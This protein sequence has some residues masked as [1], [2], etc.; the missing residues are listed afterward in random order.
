MMKEAKAKKQRS[1]S[2]STKRNKSNNNSKTKKNKWPISCLKKQIKTTL[3]QKKIATRKSKAE[4]C[5]TERHP[6]K[7]HSCVGL[8]PG[9]RAAMAHSSG[10]AEGGL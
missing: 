3:D 7:A 4:R 9:T 10:S 6:Y 5:T 2:R 8:V 1:K